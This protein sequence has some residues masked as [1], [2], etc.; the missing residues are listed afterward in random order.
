MQQ[1]QTGENMFLLIAMCF[2]CFARQLERQ[3]DWDFKWHC[4][5]HGRSSFRCRYTYTEIG[6]LWVVLCLVLCTSN[7][8]GCPKG[9]CFL[10]DKNFVSNIMGISGHLNC[11]GDRISEMQSKGPHLV[12]TSWLSMEQLLP[13]LT[14]NRP[15]LTQHFNEKWPSCSPTKSFWI[16]SFVLKGFFHTLNSTLVAIQGLSTLLN[17]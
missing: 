7:G 15:C 3:A 4:F 16:M 13:W 9:N 11:Q 1:H 14:L 17:E 2:W 6:S 12:N 5:H 10:Y 8:F